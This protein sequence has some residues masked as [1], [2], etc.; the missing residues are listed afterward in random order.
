M[1]EPPSRE[2]LRP[3]VPRNRGKTPNS[4]M[5]RA[6]S[7]LTAAISDNKARAAAFWNEFSEVE[8]SLAPLA[9]RDKF[10]A[11]NK[12]L[13]KHFEGIAAELFSNKDG[14][15]DTLC[16]SAHGKTGLFPAVMEL[17]GQAPASS[18]YKVTALRWREREARF[19]MR[20]DGF[21]LRPSDVLIGHYADGAQVGLKIGFACEIPSG[22][23]ELVHHM[24]FIMLDHIIGEYDFA[25]KVGAVDFVDGPAD[26]PP[27]STPLD[28]FPPVF[29]GFWKDGLGHTAVYPQGEPEMAGLEVT[30]R[31][32]GGE[33]EAPDKAFVILNASANAVAMRADLSYALTVTMPAGDA[34][35]LDYA[36]EKEEQ[37][38]HMLGLSC[39]GIFAYSML[40]SRQRH[41]VFY[42][43]DPLAVRSFIEK[44]TAPG[45][46]ELAG[47]YD[48]SWSKY[49]RFA[50]A[51]PNN[52]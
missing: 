10:E 26:K 4:G 52:Q 48:Y 33:G 24:A 46:F 18:P 19:T 23:E 43:S 21:E 7:T 6:M 27:Q 50:N 35:E 16:F 13:D 37:I 3:P 44:N 12:T 31:G 30:Y 36:R 22:R 8:A 38:S 15:I 20:M 17:T 47:E 1:C 14:S 40:R 49:C 32:G 42:I 25:V 28:Q 9:V 41:A 51:L 2:A 34:G 11:L 5:E 39:S 29:D 45:T